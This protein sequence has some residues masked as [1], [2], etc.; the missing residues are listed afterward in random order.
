MSSW[1]L[2]AKISFKILH[3]VPLNLYDN[4]ATLFFLKLL[5]QSLALAITFNRAVLMEIA[6]DCITAVVTGE[7]VLSCYDYSTLPF[8]GKTGPKLPK[9]PG[10]FTF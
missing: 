1:L 4:C 2:G 7:F 8:S 10:F 6:L 5:T 3:I 9:S